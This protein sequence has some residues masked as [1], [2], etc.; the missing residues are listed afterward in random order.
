MKNSEQ[1]TVL[2]T[3]ASSGIGAEL[4]KRYTADGYRAV[5]V[6][7]TNPF[8]CEHFIQ[9]DLSDPEQTRR[10]AQAAQAYAP[11]SA[12]VLN[13]GF[14]ISG[15]T[16]LL[17]EDEVRKT[18][19]VD[20]FSANFLCR[21]L[22]PQMQNGGKIVFISSACALFA[23]PFRGVYCS[24]KA[25]VNMLSFSLRME[26]SGQYDVVCICPGDIRTN[27]TQNRL[28]SHKTNI[29]YGDRVQNAADRVDGREHK[30]MKLS[31]CGKKI[32]KICRNG[33][34]ALYVIGAKYKAFMLF[35]KFLPTGV[36][37]GA[38]NRFFGGGSVQA[39]KLDNN[40]KK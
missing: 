31:V 33:R 30:R 19:E 1:K 10:A 36:M 28:K 8:G 40:A 4:Y 14:G 39:K 15:A 22:L 2:I 9:C 12:I 5:C 16:E 17:D 23:L 13:A 38:T 32:Y 6:Q 3:G 24:A 26:L 27:F 18:V 37:L 21:D 20:Y 11:Y 29:R 25:A 35:G 7:R 34:R